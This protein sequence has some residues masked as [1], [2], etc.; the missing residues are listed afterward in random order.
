[1]LQYEMHPAINGLTEVGSFFSV[2]VGCFFSGSSHRVFSKFSH[3]GK[4]NS[5]GIDL[6]VNYV[7]N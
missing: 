2:L 7:F 5:K 6:T 4:I 1:M 3:N